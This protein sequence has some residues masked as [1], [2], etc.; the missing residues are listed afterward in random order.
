MNAKTAKKLGKSEG[1][2]VKLSGAGGECAVRIHINEGVMNDVI[3]APLGF[4]H[5][6]WDVY[7]SGKGEN[8][9]KILTVGTES[10]T[11]LSVWS[12]SFVSIA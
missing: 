5:T 2:I 11:G 1:S 10:G 7:S 8:I 12:S 3:A 4:G 6:A 9:S